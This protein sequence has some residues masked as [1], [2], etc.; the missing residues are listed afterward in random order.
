VTLNDRGKPFLVSLSES[1]Q[2]MVA[3]GGI[4]ILSAK[5]VLF[6]LWSRAPF[7][8]SQGNSWSIAVRQG[9]EGKSLGVAETCR[10]SSHLLDGHQD[11]QK[12]KAGVCVY[13]SDDV[14]E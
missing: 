4:L 12:P 9:S 14:A 5:P 11:A 1:S 13:P 2:G 10:R 3:C 6:P 7:N 8:I